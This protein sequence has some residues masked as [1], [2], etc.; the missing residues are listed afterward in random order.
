MTK[1]VPAFL[2]VQVTG[3]AAKD[4]QAPALPSSLGLHSCLLKGLKLQD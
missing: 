1:L 3:L 4:P 2:Q